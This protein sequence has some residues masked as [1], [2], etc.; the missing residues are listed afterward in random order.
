MKRARFLY[1]LVISAISFFFAFIPST[2]QSPATQVT[3]V[4]PEERAKVEQAI[5]QAVN[6][7]E[8]DHLSTLIY[9]TTVM[10]LNFSSDG[11]WARTWLIS[12]DPSTGETAPIEPGL[13]VV[14]KVKDIWTVFLQADTSWLGAIQASPE[15]LFQVDEKSMWAEMYQQIQIN[16]PSAPLTGYRLPWKA[17]ETRSLSQSVLHDKYDSSHKA[18]YAFDFYT[19]G[20]MWD[21][22]AA[23]SGTVYLAKDDIPTC[24]SDHCDG[25]GSGNYIVIKDTT[26]T[27]T[28]YALYLHLAQNSIPPD[29][30]IIGARVKRGQFIAVADNTGASYGNHLHF[31]VHTSDQSWW[32]QSVDITFEDV[33]I[34]GGR[35]RVQNQFYDD[36][37]YC[38]HGGGFNDVCDDF[39]TDYVSLNTPCE[40]PD[41]TPPDGGLTI[42]ITTGASI[43]STLSLSGWGEDNQCG[44]AAG[45]FI[46]NYDGTWQ[47]IGP[48]FPTS[49][50]NY[51]WNLCDIPDG[52]IEVGL[53]LT[54][55]AVNSTIVGAR[56]LSKDYTCPAPPPPACVP[57]ADEVTLFDGT[58][59]TGTCLSFSPG[60]YTSL[61]ALDGQTSAIMVGSNVQATLFLN[62]DY[63]GRGETFF[64]ND[65][66]LT[67][68]LIGSNT[69]GSLR[70]YG[71]SQL[72][73][74]PILKSPLAG[75]EISLD[76]T[77]TFFWEN[78]GFTT[79]YQ[80]LLTYNVTDAITSTWQSEPYLNIDG[81]PAGDYVWQVRGRN[82]VAGASAWSSPFTFSIIDTGTIPIPTVP[83]PYTDTMEITPTNWSATGF[84][85]LVNNAALA[86]SGTYSWWYQ[87]SDGDYANGQPNSGDLTSPNFS[88]STVEHYYLQYYYRYTTETQGKDWDQRW[89]QISINGGP[90][91]QFLSIGQRQQLSDDP[92]ADELSDP[93]L[94][95]QVLDLGD[96][97]PGQTVRVRFHFDTLDAYKN[98]YQGWAIDDVSIRTK[99]P[100]V[101]GDPNEPNDTPQ[102]ATPITI[103]NIVNGYIR[104]QGDFDYFTFNASAGERIVA[105]IDAQSIGSSLDPYLFLIDSDGKSVLAQ[106]D[107]EVYAQ[108]RDSFIAFYAPHNGTYYIKLRAWNN[109]GVGGSQYFYNLHFYIDNA[110]PVLS[111][112]NPA[113]A[114]GFLGSQDVA[115]TA[116]A[117]DSQSGISQVDFY[118]HENDWINLNWELLGSD[119]N[120]A[121]GWSA[122]LNRPDQSGIA[123]Y[124]KAIDRSRNVAGQGYWNLSI[125]RTPPQTNLLPLTANQTSTAF[126]LEWTGND[127]LAGI[128][129]YEL[130]WAVDGATWINYPLIFTGY[131]KSTWI[132][133]SPGHSYAFRM[134]G[135]DRAGNVEAFP[136]TAETST[137]IPANVCAVPDIWEVDNSPVS[138]SEISNDQVQVHN[139]CNPET[140]DGLGD[141][142]WITITVEAGR[143][144]I[145]A[146]PISEN[147]AA[148]ISIYTGNGISLTLRTEMT[149]TIWGKPTFIDWIATNSDVLYIRVQHSDR[150]VAGS[151]VIYELYVSKNYPVFMPVISRWP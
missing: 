4:S 29:L 21:I 113:N 120:G 143:Y 37:P 74:T 102:Q 87:E 112:N 39:Q 110:D 147:T 61:G 81:L 31:M 16:L 148:A 38:L 124:V 54:D 130:Q 151:S 132:I 111:F 10:D 117:S 122:P 53:R 24:Y 141:T 118:I 129:Y 103:G 11:Q 55:Q 66:I 149:Q 128:D 142:D 80:V 108:N 134:H 115:L 85:R 71:R 32:G 144:L 78:G 2:A 12:T 56:S 145:Q 82:P 7:R 46:A 8:A 9:Q 60:N 35:P 114:N 25:Q 121:D 48:A 1:F 57:S 94:S 104:P 59:Y 106:N 19:H 84:W 107:D 64:T 62:Q 5:Y 41:N 47:N 68:N 92:F 75:S 49:P 96:L 83:V 135:I 27:P 34:N 105:D 23:K 65:N 95:S 136:P 138:A 79:D 67:D 18:H 15:S 13:A 89:V 116:F 90:F 123:L 70:V 43:T 28:S 6:L 72:P 125:D 52:P 101:P 42:P 109:P 98:E 45:Q 40:I 77:V 140:T 150:R 76:D 26:T 133:G 22:Y 137:T 139:F 58:D 63:T 17:G 33:F 88:I 146:L 50:F 14:H 99:P 100:D 51:D 36:E 97:N 93:Y 91:R 44:L 3:P 127:N 73:L 69:T 30:K 20:T 86:H 119:T 131:T 126:Q